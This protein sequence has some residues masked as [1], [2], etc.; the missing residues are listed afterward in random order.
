MPP[1]FAEV[2]ETRAVVPVAIAPPGRVDAPSVAFASTMVVAPA[3]PLTWYDCTFRLVATRGAFT[4]GGNWARFRCETA[5][6]RSNCSG[7]PDAAGATIA[8]FAVAVPPY[9]AA[10]PSSVMWRPF[11]SAVT[12]T[13][14]T[15]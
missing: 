5:P 4:L 14:D 12:L 11:A 10:R 6:P 9:A 7:W 15:R 13:S 1:R 3:W 8:P 2:I